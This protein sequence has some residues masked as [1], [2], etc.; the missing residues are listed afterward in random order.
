MFGRWP[1]CQT[2][3][4]P[5]IAAGP[6][7]PHEIDAALALI[8]DPAGDG[9]KVRDFRRFARAKAV[10][11]A[12]LVVARAGRR[13]VWAALPIESPGRTALV[14]VPD[15]APRH[16]AGAA[17]AVLDRACAELAARGVMLAQVLTEPGS[18]TA[19]AAAAAGFGPLAEL[20][21]YVRDVPRRPVP[22]ERVADGVAWEAY[23]AANHDRFVEVL[24]ATYAG[25]LDCPALTGVRDPADVL[26][27]HRAAGDFE[28]G[29]W[30]LM[31]VGGAPAGLLLMAGVPGSAAAE[32]VYVGLLPEAR[33]RRVGGARLADLLI[34]RALHLCRARRRGPI[35][36]AADATNGPAIRLYRRH[37]MAEAH[38]RLA[39]MRR[40]VP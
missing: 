39:L 25:S 22:A 40:L 38:R 3:R 37:G 27:G 20:A 19:V 36:L 23:G 7:E 30:E 6:A 15:T 26:L 4:S 29:M 32:I 16:P 24:A 13:V 12:Q 35:T 5:C 8:L 14:L 9:A 28:P 18:S 17:G 31:H 10:D 33:G 2:R 11:L 21:Y 34:G 1:T